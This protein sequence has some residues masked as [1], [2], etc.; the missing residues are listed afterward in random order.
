MKLHEP[1][2][3]PCKK[4]TRISLQKNNPDFPAKNNPEP[5]CQKKAR[6]GIAVTGLKYCGCYTGGELNTHAHHPSFLQH[7]LFA[8]VHK[9]EILARTIN[10]YKYAELT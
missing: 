3:F 1:D 7:V 6:Y 10:S 9:A 5:G 4:T 8:S 2:L